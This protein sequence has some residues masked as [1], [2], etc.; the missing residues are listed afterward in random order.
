VKPEASPI[1]VYKEVGKA[2]AYSVAADVATDSMLLITFTPEGTAGKTDP[3]LSGVQITSAPAFTILAPADGEV[4]Q[5]GQQTSITWETNHPGL[6]D[7]SIEVS[8]N[9]GKNW[10]LVTPTESIKRSDPRWQA[11]PWQVPGKV[12]DMVLT[13]HEC[14]LRIMDYNQDFIV[15]MEGTFTVQSAGAVTLSRAGARETARVVW[16]P[17]T[18]CL[19]V[20]IL[21]PQGGRA[22]LTRTNGVCIDAVD[23]HSPGIMVTRTRGLAGGVYLLRV[24]TPAGE[25]MRVLCLP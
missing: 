10:E 6:D 8:N 3:I 22:V 4:L 14:V 13:N 16:S 12:G 15:H 1:D 21:H 20:D 18:R 23:L 7:A 19:Y 5:V 24:E 9:G 17:A 11:F 2:A 25:H